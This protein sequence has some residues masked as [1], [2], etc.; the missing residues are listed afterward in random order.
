MSS[1]KNWIN[2][3]TGFVNPG[4]I[5]VSGFSNP[6]SSGNSGFP[7]PGYILFIG[8]HKSGY[9]NPIQI[10]ISGILYPDLLNPVVEYIPDF[11][12]R[13]ML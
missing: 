1:L 8:Y 11:N 4:K 3:L 7:N 13:R 5:I 10:L 6:V 12:I 2:A 9:N